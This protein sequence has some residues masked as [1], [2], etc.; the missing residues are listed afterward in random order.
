MPT[1][2]SKELNQRSI[3]GIVSGWVMKTSKQSYWLAHL[4]ATLE[5]PSSIPTQT[6]MHN[7]ASFFVFPFAELHKKLWAKGCIHLFF[8]LLILHVWL[9]KRL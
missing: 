7:F 8:K 6:W 3:E 1:R 5:D 9:L 4:A 2:S